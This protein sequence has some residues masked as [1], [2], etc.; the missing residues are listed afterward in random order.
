MRRVGDYQQRCRL[1]IASR[2]NN[3]LYIVKEV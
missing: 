3:L 2:G 1:A